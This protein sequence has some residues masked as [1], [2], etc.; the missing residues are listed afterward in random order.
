M[1]SWS[2]ALVVRAMLSEIFPV[3]ASR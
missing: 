1:K 3:F 2:Q